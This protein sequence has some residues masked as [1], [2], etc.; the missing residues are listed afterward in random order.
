MHAADFVIYNNYKNYIINNKS[1]KRKILNLR[2][3]EVARSVFTETH[4]CRVC[5][6][7]GFINTRTDRYMRG[8]Y[9]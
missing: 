8:W 7:M 1:D 9:L 3:T 2:M 6:K 5:L 4:Q